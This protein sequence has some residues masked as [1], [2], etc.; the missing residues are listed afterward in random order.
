MNFMDVLS[1][2]GVLNGKILVFLNPV[3]EMLEDV[4]C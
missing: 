2:S 4:T 3:L 1:G